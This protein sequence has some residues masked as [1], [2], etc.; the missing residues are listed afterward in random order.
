MR[1]CT[2]RKTEK[3]THRNTV[4]NWKVRNGVLS[5][6]RD[7]RINQNQSIISHSDKSKARLCGIYCVNAFEA[8]TRDGCTWE[9]LKSLKCRF[10]IAKIYQKFALIKQYVYF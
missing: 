9:I 3:K 10:L 1:A 8:G 7:K 6:M 5:I 4:Q 2:E